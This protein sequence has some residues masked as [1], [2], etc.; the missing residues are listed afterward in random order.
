[1][2][3][4]SR[5][6]VHFVKMMY[7][8]VVVAASLLIQAEMAVS[9]VPSPIAMSCTAAPLV[10]CFQDFRPNRTFPI[11][12]SSQPGDPFNGN[13]TLETCAFLCNG[14]Q[15]PLAGVEAGDQ[16]FCADTTANVTAFAAPM[17][18]C[19]GASATACVGNTFQ[20][21]GG[22]WRVGVYNYTCTPY[23]DSG[24]A[25]RNTSLTPEARVDDLVY[26]LSDASTPISALF[27]QLV[28]NGADIYAPLVQLPRYIVS[29]ECLAGYDGGDIYIAPP[30]PN[31]NY[32]SA[33]PQPVNLGNTFD[34]TLVRAIASQISDEARA[35]WYHYGR[36]ALTCMSP[37]LNMAR[38]PQWGRNCESY[39]EDPTLIGTLGSAY[40]RGIQEGNEGDAARYYNGTSIWKI[41]AV[42]KHLGA[43]SVE[44][45][46]PDGG[47]N[48]YPNC[49][50][51]RSFFNSVI[52]N[53][54]DLREGYLPGWERAVIQGGAGS[55]MA[56]YNAINGVPMAANGG[57]LRGI[58]QG[59]W[60]ASGFVISDAG[61]V[62]FVG[63]A[64]GADTPG[65]N[66]TSTLLG[67]VVSAVTNGTGVSLEADANDFTSAYHTQLATAVQQGLLSKADLVAA[68]RRTLLPRFQAGLY[69]P[70]SSVPWNRINTSTIES[71]YAHQLA[72]LAA[73]D[74]YVLLANTNSFLPLKGAAKGGPKS[75]AVVGP[76]ANCTSCIINRYTGSPRTVVTHWEGIAVGAAANGATAVLA[77]G[78]GAAAV[79]AVAAADVGIVILTSYPE[80]ESRDRENIGIP[81]DQLAFLMDLAANT[82]TPLVVCT[83]SGGA[84]DVSPVLALGQ[85]V[86]ALLALYQGGMEAGNALADVLYGAVNPSAALAATV[87]RRTWEN[88]SSFLDMSLS[89]PPGRGHRYLRADAAAAHVVFPFGYGLSYTTWHDSVTALWPRT[90][91]ASSLAAGSTVTVGV[92]VMNGGGAAGRRVVLL[93][94]A[95]VGYGPD[96]GWPNQWL[97]Q[98][99]IDKT[100]TLAYNEGVDYPVHI[101]ARDVSRWDSAANA[102]AI[103][104]GN[105]SLAVRDASAGGA[106][107]PPQAWFEVTA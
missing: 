60:N 19:L 13:M 61:G 46:N 58:L 102:W 42:P 26:R 71:P 101:T 4:S 88:A 99:G 10:G 98:E 18:D 80:G 91:S 78:E 92:T 67:A 12:P 8:G 2:T 70:P 82:T 107:G 17:A 83:V 48:E 104:P 29:Q 75:I 38:S 66:F 32:S 93:Y 41:Q 56:S 30:V 77:G 35:A 11:N 6:N 79:A 59:E 86:L 65:H 25:W 44:C 43:Y 81:D 76:G 49:P 36:P 106:V 1:M 64:T 31:L 27:A 97:A 33:F 96:D 52:D 85:R 45:F 47:N 69:D 87:Y 57:V 94:I 72:R 9:I 37:N 20:M 95:R 55:V 28:Q 22:P 24:A 40:V 34:A 21:C 84:V 14:L 50:I 90:I 68:A 39:G 54:A 16:C 51:Y 100:Q 103:V 73:A 53:D 3:S 15:L 5:R 62:S 7:S 23:D 63:P 89:A 105:Y 74:S